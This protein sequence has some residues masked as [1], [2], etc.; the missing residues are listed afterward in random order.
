MTNN[1]IRYGMNTT[2]SSSSIGTVA[3]VAPGFW[4][5]NGTLTWF[6]GTTNHKID[7]ATDTITNAF[8]TIVIN[9]I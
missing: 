9:N 5:D 8:G 6:D 4:I 7:F 1:I 2:G 3:P